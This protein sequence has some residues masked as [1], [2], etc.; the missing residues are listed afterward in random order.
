VTCQLDLMT[1][2][3]RATLSSD[4]IASSFDLAECFPSRQLKCADDSFVRILHK[5]RKEY[6]LSHIPVLVYAFKFCFGK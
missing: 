3:T 2:T 1:C 4:P 5:L 6:F